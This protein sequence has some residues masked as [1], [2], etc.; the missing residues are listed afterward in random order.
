MSELLRKL[1]DEE[2]YYDYTHFEDIP[3]L[4][5]KKDKVIIFVVQDGCSYCKMVEPFIN[6]YAKNN[7]DVVYAVVAN[8][9]ENY[10]TQADKYKLMGTPTLIFYEK[11][12]EVFR[13]GKGFTDD[14]FQEMI[15]KVDF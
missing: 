3:K 4:V 7:K 12:K 13:K 15:K 9:E 5:E 6:D 10:N 11:G 1:T 14:E 8:K 2:T